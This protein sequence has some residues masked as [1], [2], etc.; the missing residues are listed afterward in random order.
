M[1]YRHGQDEI[2][3]LQIERQRALDRHLSRDRSREHSFDCG[4]EGK[5]DNSV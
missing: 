4:R 3:D 1:A 5:S 2:V